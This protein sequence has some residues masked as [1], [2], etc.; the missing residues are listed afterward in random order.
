M[1][2]SKS[3]ER[4]LFIVIVGAVLAGISFFG[5]CFSYVIPSDVWLLGPLFMML[6]MVK[7]LDDKNRD[8]KAAFLKGYTG[9]FLG[10]FLVSVIISI[11]HSIPLLGSQ[12]G[13]IFF[14]MF[15]FYQISK[16]LSPEVKAGA[17]VAGNFLYFLIL[18]YYYMTLD[19]FM[20]IL[21]YT[22]NRLINWHENPNIL[23]FTVV[24]FAILNSKIFQS[25]KLLSVWLIVNYIFLYILRSEGAIISLS[26]MFLF[27]CST[28]TLVSILAF[29]A[30]III[31]KINRE[32]NF[33][34]RFTLMKEAFH[35]GLEAPFF[36]KGYNI[37]LPVLIVTP[38]PNKIEF[39]IH[40]HNSVLQA[41]QEAGFQ[42]LAVIIYFIF[43]LQKFWEFLSLPAKQLCL[44]Y[45]IWSLFDDPFYFISSAGL[46]AFAMTLEVEK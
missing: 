12:R 26:S 8:S 18:S 42:A 21:P 6:L 31:Y 34:S 37:R 38:E 2:E 11:Y 33:F 7:K 40:A 1:I 10:F 17:L 46:F 44:A 41:F 32:E 19:R 45:G 13:L 22:H 29:S 3:I 14:W 20:L 39:A 30:L 27:W 43:K 28:T 4:I 35:N 5:C 9:P 36:G 15:F 25:I 24:A 16:D 23:A